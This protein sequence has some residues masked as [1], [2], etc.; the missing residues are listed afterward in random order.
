MKYFNLL[1]FAQKIVEDPSLDYSSIG[2]TQ[3]RNT[4]YPTSKAVSKSVDPEKDLIQYFENGVVK[5][6]PGTRT[7]GTSIPMQKKYYRG[8]YELR[9]N[10][11]AVSVITPWNVYT[12]Q[13]L[14]DIL[15]R[16]LTEKF[17][18]DITIYT[19]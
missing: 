8:R 18:D 6:F 1:K 3:Y 15:V 19:F 7:H 12:H 14:P 5:T 10:G 9:E 16:R 13:P 11:G 4:Y 2:H 17:G